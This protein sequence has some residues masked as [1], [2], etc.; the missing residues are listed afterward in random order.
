MPLFA[1]NVMMRGIMSNKKRKKKRK[2]KNDWWKL[3]TNVILFS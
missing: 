3:G 2:P 1:L